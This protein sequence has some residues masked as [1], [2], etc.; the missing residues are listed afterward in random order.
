VYPL[1]LLRKSVSWEGGRLSFEMLNLKNAVIVF[2]Y[3]SERGLG[4]L[5]FAL[6][7]KEGFGGLSTVLIGGKY[8]LL[9]RIVAERVA[10]YYGRPVLASIN[11]TLPEE[12]SMERVAGLLRSLPSL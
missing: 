4:T 12:E 7:G 5:A 10:H 2:L 11:L 8:R 9:S 6:P 1:K 3:D